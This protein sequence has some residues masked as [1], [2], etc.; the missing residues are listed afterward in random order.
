VFHAEP[1]TE[2]AMNQLRSEALGRLPPDIEVMDPF[3]P[4]PMQISTGMPVGALNI[5]PRREAVESVGVPQDGEILVT[6]PT[7][8]AGLFHAC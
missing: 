4:A 5:A 2:S 6:G 8:P 3:L 1:L 7:G